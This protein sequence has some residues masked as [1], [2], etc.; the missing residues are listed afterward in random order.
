M[1][2]S[3]GIERWK[4]IERDGGTAS[5]TNIEVSETSARPQALFIAKREKERESFEFNLSKCLYFF[6][7]SISLRDPRSSPPLCS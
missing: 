7:A 3:G 2:R 6:L 5:L 1:R 4:D